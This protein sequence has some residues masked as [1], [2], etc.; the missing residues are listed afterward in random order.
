M[1]MFIDPNPIYTCICLHLFVICANSSD[2][3]FETPH[4]MECV[5]TK[6]KVAPP[7]ER[8]RSCSVQQ[9]VPAMSLSEQTPEGPTQN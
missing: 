7:V 9:P 2:F 1:R 5:G 6:D 8:L 3:I 4:N